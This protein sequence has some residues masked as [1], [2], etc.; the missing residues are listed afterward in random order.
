[1]NN[2]LKLIIFTAPSG[3]GK[4]TIVKSLLDKFS[5]LFFTCTYTTREPRIG[6]MNGVDYHFIS[7]EEFKNKIEEGFFI[8]YEEVYTDF[9]GSSNKIIEENYKKGRIALMILEV[10]GALNMKNFYNNEVLTIFVK[11]PDLLTLKERL[12]NRGTETEEKINSRIERA[13]HELLYENKYDYILLNNDLEIA[14]ETITKEIEQYV[15]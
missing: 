6:E 4:T 5:K 3:A 8:E 1:M 7:K 9:Y 10:K 11:V 13:K 12:I 2:D 15:R 14:I